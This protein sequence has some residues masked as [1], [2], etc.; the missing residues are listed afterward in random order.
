MENTFYKLCS[1]N[2]SVQSWPV[3]LM[4]TYVQFVIF[5]VCYAMNCTN[6]TSLYF[7]FEINS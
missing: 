7:T 6:S 2:F 5:T 1:E 3:G 4:N